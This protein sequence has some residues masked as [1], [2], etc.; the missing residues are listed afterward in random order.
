MMTSKEDAVNCN[1]EQTD[2][3]LQMMEAPIPVRRPDGLQNRNGHGGIGLEFMAVSRNF[4]NG[5]NCYQCV[6]FAQQSLA[7]VSLE[8]QP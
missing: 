6:F 5:S 1:E 7:N 8:W 3:L 4:S 2:E